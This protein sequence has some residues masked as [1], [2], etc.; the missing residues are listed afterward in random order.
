[1]AIPTVSRTAAATPMMAD[2]FHER[3]A[4]PA[5]WAHRLA[6]FAVMLMLLS[7][8]GHRTGL[9]ETV[10]FL[11][12]LAIGG[13]LALAAVA[14]AVIAFVQLWRHGVGNAWR[15]VSGMLMA[16]LV[17]APFAVSA[18][19]MVEHPQLADIATDTADPPAFAVADARRD[20]AMNPIAPVGAE[21]AALQREHYPDITGRRYEQAAESVLAT[22]REMIAEREWRLL[23]PGKPDTAS[24]S[25]T[26][27]AVAFSF[28]L[29]FS[30]DVAIRVVDREAATFVDMRSVSRYGRH[31]LGDNAARIRRFLDDLDE[32]IARHADI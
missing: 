18:V 2:D 26:V 1:M 10:P 28:L 9:V 23:T 27:E 8:L 13:A 22:I 25:V 5:I 32:R 16:A 14:L 31:D 24:G 30:S 29:G 3:T 21:A 4:F 6:A 17:L 20:G 7:G 12:L 15:A 11:W 19:R